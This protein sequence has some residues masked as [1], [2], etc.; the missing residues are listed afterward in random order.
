MLDRI[1]D[2]LNSAPEVDEWLINDKQTESAE[3]FF[4]KKKLDMNRSKK[5]H[6]I[7]ITVYKNF[8]EGGVKYK[9]SASTRLSPTMTEEEIRN[10][11]AQA[12]LAA[13]LVKNPY[14]ELVSPT[15]EMVPD[16]SSKF[17]TGELASYMPELA[18]ALYKNDTMGSSKVNS[19]EFFLEKTDAK[20]INSL[21]VDIRFMTYSGHI[22][23]VVDCIQSGEEIEII[24][25]FDFSDLCLDKISQTTTQALENA[26]LR[27]NAVP[28]P[29]LENV[30]VILVKDNVNEFL[31]YYI[32]KA[33][34][35]LVYQKYSDAKVGDDVQG[36]DVKGDRINAVLEPEI[37][38]S[39]MNRYVDSDGV[40]LVSTQLYKDGRLLRYHGDNRYS[41]YMNTPPTGMIGNVRFG[42]GKSSLGE[43]KS[44]QYLELIYFSDFQMDEWTGD[45]GGEIRLAVYHDGEKSVPVTG[46]SIVGNIK[47]VQDSMQLSSDM[48][49][50]AN[51][52]CP[53]GIKLS[54][55][56]IAV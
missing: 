53:K 5:V 28:T 16:V 39:A 21:G 36:A 49:T 20:V 26:L 3:L 30:P 27:A 41:Q 7:N 46:G 34:A 4:I 54:G 45:F 52:I 19:C 51:Y 35:Q 14:Y 33:N 22:E 15:N 13:A 40:K 17:S 47:N 55:V 31:R 44:G 6:H 18:N 12:A 11:V 56:T 43:L 42:G 10:K 2:I 8:E 48:Q 38:N 50:S 23:L 32:A 25:F 37:E 9:G 29:K 1:I 24:E